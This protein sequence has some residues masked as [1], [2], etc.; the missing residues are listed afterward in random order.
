MA[1]VSRVWEEGELTMQEDHGIARF[2]EVFG[3]CGSPRPS[4]E[5]IDE[6][7]RLVFK[8]YGGAT[9]GDQNHSAILGAVLVYERP[10]NGDVGVQLRRRRVDAEV[11]SLGDVSRRVSLYQWPC[12]HGGLCLLAAGT[13]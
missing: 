4:R 2:K 8:R 10:C 9:G 1:V 3:G 6:S 5:V 7:H 12:R 11:I 13:L